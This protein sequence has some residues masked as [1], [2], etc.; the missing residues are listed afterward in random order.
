VCP[1]VTGDRPLEREGLPARKP[2]RPRKRGEPPQ[3]TLGGFLAFFTAITVCISLVVTAIRIGDDASRAV[4]LGATAI[5]AWI[6]LFVTYRR[7]QLHV[8]LAIHWLTVAAPLGAV[9]LCSLGLLVKG[10][11]QDGVG[12]SNFAGGVLVMFPAVAIGGAVF[13]SAFSLPV[14]VVTMVVRLARGVSRVRLV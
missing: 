14:F 9:A 1:R 8:A 4:L 7:L 12:T 2:V 13:G 6:S 5:V 3:F 10:L 11:L